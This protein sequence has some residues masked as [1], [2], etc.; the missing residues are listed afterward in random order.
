[1]FH[2]ILYLMNIIIWSY[3]Y[4]HGYSLLRAYYSLPESNADSLP[5]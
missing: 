5:L 4:N 3:K 2:D 1:M